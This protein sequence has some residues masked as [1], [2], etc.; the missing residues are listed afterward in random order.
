MSREKKE[1]IQDI[2][3][4]L[5][6][7]NVNVPCDDVIELVI[8]RLKKSER[9][10]NNSVK[11]MKKYSSE[12][13]EV[14]VVHVATTIEAVTHL[15]GDCTKHGVEGLKPLSLLNSFITSCKG[16]FVNN[17]DVKGSN[18]KTIAFRSASD[19]VL[20]AKLLFL[21]EPSIYEP[22]SKKTVKSINSDNCSITLTNEEWEKSKLD[23]RL[24]QQVQSVS[25]SVAADGAVGG[26]GSASRSNN[27]PAFSAA[28]A[29]AAVVA[30]GNSPATVRNSLFLGGSANSAVLAPVVIEDGYLDS[31]SEINNVAG[32]DGTYCF[33]FSTADAAQ[34]FSGRL[35]TLVSINDVTIGNKVCLTDSEIK[36]AGLHKNALVQALKPELNKPSNVPVV[37][38]G[39]SVAVGTEY[40]NLYEDALEEEANQGYQAR[41]GSQAAAVTQRRKRKSNVRSSHK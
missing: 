5:E 38:T 32:V 15:Q 39:A 17:H 18:S 35:V 10:K 9:Y 16:G 19:A 34:S 37:A 29:A 2:R 20:Y 26:G 14:L 13:L 31:L 3:R 28:A 25:S 4:Y 41:H 7:K 23:T 12:E 21:L 27:A 8:D 24:P 33:V 6:G 36:Q 11:K 40:V 1:V 30:S 22:G